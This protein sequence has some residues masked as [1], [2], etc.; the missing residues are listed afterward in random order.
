MIVPK[1]FVLSKG[2]IVDKDD[3]GLSLFTIV[4]EIGTNKLP[5]VIP[6]L[7]AAGLFELID[8]EP[9]IFNV[10]LK[11]LNNDKVIMEYKGIPSDFKSKSIHKILIKI[12][13]LKIEEEGIININLSTNN[14]VFANYKVEV[15]VNK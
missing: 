12:N 8:E 14:N 3:N 6:E 7:S 13:G 10:D 4:E 2:S 1:F 11:I 5:L 9:Q 15:K